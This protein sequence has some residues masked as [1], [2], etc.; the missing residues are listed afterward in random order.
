M[1]KKLTTEEKLEIIDRATAEAMIKLGK[2]IKEILE[3]KPWSIV[4]I[5]L[6]A[7]LTDTLVVM[8]IAQT[9]ARKVRRKLNRGGN[10]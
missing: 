7:K 4:K 2:F 9:I 5:G 8:M 10:I 6:N 3:A 1:K